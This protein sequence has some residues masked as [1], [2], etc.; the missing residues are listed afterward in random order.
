MISTPRSGC[1]FGLNSS[2]VSALS[3][4]RAEAIRDGIVRRRA[5]R[6]FAR[7]PEGGLRSQADLRFASRS[8]FRPTDSRSPRLVWPLLAAPQKCFGYSL[9]GFMI[10]AAGQLLADGFQRHFQSQRCS[11]QIVA[12]DAGMLSASSAASG[13]FHSGRSVPVPLE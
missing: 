1:R 9:A 8:A 4:S 3:P 12:L 5:R 13:G 2:Q 10:A 7:G 6:P 11:C